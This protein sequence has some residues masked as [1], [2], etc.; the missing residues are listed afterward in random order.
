MD[1]IKKSRNFRKISVGL[2]SAFII[3][4]FSQCKNKGTLKV[5]KNWVAEI[6]PPGRIA[7]A[8]LTIV[9]PTDADDSL[10]SIDSEDFEKAEFHGMTNE[11]GM[12]KMEAM[13]F[14]PV[15]AGST[16]KFEPGG[17]HI[18]LINNKREIKAGLNTTLNLHFQNAGLI[19][20]KCPI[21]KM[22]DME[23]EE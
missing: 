1:F 2:L 5:E 12:M 10:L 13:D 16:V 19:S 20:V 6:I 9:N 23:N 4:S 14:V 8:Y 7:A 17:M 21:K 11:D 15:K 22:E 3:V 18:M